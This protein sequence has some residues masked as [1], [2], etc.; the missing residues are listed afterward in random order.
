MKLDDTR[1]TVFK[2]DFNPQRDAAKK[3]GKDIPGKVLYKKD[4]KYAIHYKVLE[5][6]KGRGAKF[7]AER[8]DEKRALAERKA[9]LSKVK[10]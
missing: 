7:T 3:N 1:I 9:R 4:G 6:I 5:K 10:A 8:Y 2:E